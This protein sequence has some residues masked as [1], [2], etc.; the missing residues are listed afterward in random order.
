[1]TRLMTCAVGA[2]I[3]VTALACNDDKNEKKHLSAAIESVKSACA[4]ECEYDQACYA[5]FDRMYPSL[6]ACKDEC[7]NVD[8]I[9]L[10]IASNEC[11]EAIQEVGACDV[12]EARDAIAECSM[13][14]EAC[15]ALIDAMAARCLPQFEAYAKPHLQKLGASCHTACE[16]E[17]ECLND[18]DEYADCKED[19]EN[20]SGEQSALLAMFSPACFDALNDVV[21]CDAARACGD[22]ATCSEEEENTRQ[23]CPI[24]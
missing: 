5:H 7:D 1:M 2:L 3:A 23:H 15:D 17:Y 16:T 22:V 20:I 24:F 9:Y 18:E 4:A 6:Q 12:S 10:E 11:L 13:D 19:C 21:R 14:D 8:K